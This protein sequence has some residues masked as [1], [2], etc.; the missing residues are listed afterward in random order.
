MSEYTGFKSSFLGGFDRKS[1]IEYIEKVSAELNEYK[2]KCDTLENEKEKLSAENSTLRASCAELTEECAKLSEELQLS[3]DELGQQEYAMS[4]VKDRMASYE[5]DA[6]IRAAMIEKKARDR[7]LEVKN[8][9]D[10]ALESL[11]IEYD[12]L[13]AQL[14][15]SADSI[16]NDIAEFKASVEKFS[17]A[18]AAGREKLYG[19]DKEEQNVSEEE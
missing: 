7:A 15:D 9:A 10:E 12:E 6:S 13:S 14:R 11:C 16:E 17:S 3:R 19:L 1:V 5:I 2:S 18:I 4:A 8:R